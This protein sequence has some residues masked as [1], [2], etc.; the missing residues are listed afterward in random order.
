MLR[1]WLALTAGATLVVGSA[2]A[3]V[4]FPAPP[5]AGFTERLLTAIG[6]RIA[7][8]SVSCDIPG[9]LDVGRR[10]ACHGTDQSGGYVVEVLITD[11]HHDFRLTFARPV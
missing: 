9:T 7:G 6:A 10:F 2:A 4:G 11:I 3:I 1:W 8:G 5:D